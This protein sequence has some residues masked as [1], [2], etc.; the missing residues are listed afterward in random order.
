[1]ESLGEQPSHSAIPQ[2]STTRKWHQNGLFSSKG[3]AGIRHPSDSNASGCFSWKCMP[4]GLLDVGRQRAGVQRFPPHSKT[5]HRPKPL[6][7]VKDN[8]IAMAVAAWLPYSSCLA[9]KGPV[10][11]LGIQVTTRQGLFERR[12]GIIGYCCLL[13]VRLPGS[14]PPAHAS[15]VAVVSGCVARGR[16]WHKKWAESLKGR[17]SNGY[18]DHRAV[19]AGCCL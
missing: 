1:V 4:G 15:L 9:R 16:N 3:E 14:T 6:G 10:I 13:Q 2:H 17:A 7:G 12:K 19:C 11:I 5:E 8:I 18:K